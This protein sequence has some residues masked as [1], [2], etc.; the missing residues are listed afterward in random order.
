[1]K[2]LV[3]RLLLL[4]LAAPLAA[5][6]AVSVSFPSTY[7]ADIG[8]PGAEADDVK[9]ELARHLQR[10]GS[11]WLAP[12][13]TLRVEVLDVDLAGERELVAA[14]RDLRIARG[15]ADFPRITLRYSL[16]GGRTLR[17]EDSIADPSYLWFGS[18]I[19]MSEKLYHEKRLLDHWF[20]DRF[21]R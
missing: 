21:G 12:E 10:L 7:Y 14:G 4:A 20:R 11:R 6:G 16:E 5:L 1:M 2:T 15:R 8:E 19:R 9:A 3:S 18:R 13:E 17:G